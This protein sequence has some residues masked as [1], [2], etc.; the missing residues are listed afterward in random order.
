MGPYGYGY[1]VWLG[2]RP[3]SFTFN[4]MLGQT[5]VGYPDLDLVIATNAG[6]LSIIHIWGNPDAAT[7]RG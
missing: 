4:G 1:Q 7:P 5:V 2:G 3:G 6:S